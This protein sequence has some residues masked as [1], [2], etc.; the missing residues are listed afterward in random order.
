M[1]VLYSCLLVPLPLHTQAWLFHTETWLFRRVGRFVL[2]NKDVLYNGTNCRTVFA[3]VD[4]G[5]NM[6]KLSF[7]AAT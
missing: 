6:N 7:D 4:S 5:N 2:P 1:I 3:N